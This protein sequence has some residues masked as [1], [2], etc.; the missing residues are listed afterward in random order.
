MGYFI[1]KMSDM[2]HYSDVSTTPAPPLSE[3]NNTVIHQNNLH[4]LFTYFLTD[5]F[6][7]LNLTKFIQ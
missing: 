3:G 6:S 4:Q 2:G 5:F 7:D 1:F